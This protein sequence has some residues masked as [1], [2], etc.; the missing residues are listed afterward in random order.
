MKLFSFI[1]A[2]FITLAPLSSL[3]LEGS[4][5]WTKI[6]FKIKG[7]WSIAEVNDEHVLTLS[8][9][10]KTKGAPDLKLFLSTKDISAINNENATEATHFIA[11]LK[12]KKGGQTYTI[13]KSVDLSSY[14]SI[15]I[16]CEKY[17]K[18]WGGTNLTAP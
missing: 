6:N 12:S 7:S 11:P 8:D 5:A 18:V 16:H 1:S 17:S 3:A 2:I 13:P 4:G 9:D 10:F 15:V 14:K